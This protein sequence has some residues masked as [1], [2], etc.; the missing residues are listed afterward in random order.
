M[1]HTAVAVVVDG[2]DGDGAGVDDN[3][4]DNGD[5]VPPTRTSHSDL[6]RL[7]KCNTW[8]ARNKR[9]EAKE[10][11]KYKHIAYPFEAPFRVGIIT[12]VISLFN[13]FFKQNAINVTTSGCPQAPSKGGWQLYHKHF[14]PVFK[15]T[16]WRMTSKQSPRNVQNS[17]GMTS[18]P[19]TSSIPS[20][21]ALNVTTRSCRRSPRKAGLYG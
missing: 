12:T 18:S 6:Y 2:V 17:I 9:H 1:I 20:R 8:P 11:Y 15:A 19:P 13:V 4:D 14:W 16:I 5:S 21:G 3:N 7:D 10:K